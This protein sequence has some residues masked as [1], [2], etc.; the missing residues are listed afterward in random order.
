MLKPSRKSADIP[1]FIVMDVLDRA[2]SMERDGFDVIHM[3]VGEPDFDT[4][5]KIVEAGREA[6]RLGHTHYTHSLGDPD[7]REALAGHYERTYG[8]VA[9]PG[10]I[11]CTMGSSPAMLMT[12]TAL[13]DQGDEIILPDPS[14]ACYPN[15]IRHAGGVPVPVRVLEE[16]GFQYDPTE[17]QKR[18]SPRT[19]GIIV[20]S[21]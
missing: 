12:F 16:A 19:K 2:C 7:L 21:P 9:D 14:Y 3:E 10:C 13:L 11:L 18:I 15:M 5:A 17:I 20:N 4:P 1:P 6:L 8:V